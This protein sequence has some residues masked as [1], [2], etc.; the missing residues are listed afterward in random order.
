LTVAERFIAGCGYPG[1]NTRPGVLHS[2]TRGQCHSKRTSVTG[3]HSQ[4]VATGRC[5]DRMP[6]VEPGFYALYVAMYRFGTDG[7]RIL[8]GFGNGR[9][10]KYN[11]L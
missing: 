4:E 8:L 3:S 10:F 5:I 11:Q 6:I 9:Y 1:D 7:G 2:H